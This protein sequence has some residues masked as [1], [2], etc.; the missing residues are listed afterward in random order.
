MSIHICPNCGSQKKFRLHDHPRSLNDRLTRLLE[1]T[2]IALDSLVALCADL[3]VEVP[4]KGDTNAMFNPYQP[5]AECEIGAN[6]HP[7]EGICRG[8]FALGTA[9]GHCRR[10]LQEL[11]QAILKQRDLEGALFKVK[12]FIENVRLQ[13][14]KE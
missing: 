13:G 9:C 4:K 8:S 3:E 7:N 12:R 6:L 2:T 5:P 11:P 14:S 1:V 10:C